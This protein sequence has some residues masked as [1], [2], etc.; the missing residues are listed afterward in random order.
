MSLNI[1]ILESSRSAAPSATLLLD[2]YPGAAAAYSLR[3]LRT[4]YTGSAIR[5]RRSS[6]NA[7]TDIGFNGSGGLDTTTLLT[8]CGVNTGIVVTWYDQSGN[9][10]NA[11][12]VFAINRN[13]IVNSGVLQTLNTKPAISSPTFILTPF[14]IIGDLSYFVVQRKITATAAGMNIGSSADLSLLFANW[15]DGNTYFQRSNGTSGFYIF[16]LDTTTGNQILNAFN[17]SGLMSMYKNNSQYTTA[18]PASFS[19][20]N[21]Q[22]DNI[23]NA[24][25]SVSN[26]LGTEVIIYTNSQL[27]N[28]TGINTNINTFYSIY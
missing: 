12:K 4:A 27:S 1:G 17:Q 24:S 22:F 6:D 25:S 2:T 13:I 7:E 11:T 15:H 26:G 3:K 18:A 8:F 20:A 9:S 5:V 16:A 19:I 21:S 23:G 10:R 28:R 14:T